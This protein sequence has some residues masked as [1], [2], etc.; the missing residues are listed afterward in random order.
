LIEDIG[1]LAVVRK[2]RVFEVLAYQLVECPT[3]NSFLSNGKTPLIAMR[4]R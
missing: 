3:S 4:L 2:R 1:K